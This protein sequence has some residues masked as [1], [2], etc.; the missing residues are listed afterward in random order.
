[1]KQETRDV[2]GMLDAWEDFDCSITEAKVVEVIAQAAAS[3]LEAES[4]NV[5]VE[6][7]DSWNWEA[8]YKSVDPGWY[9]PA[10][11]EE[12]TTAIKQE[13]MEFNP[14][15]SSRSHQHGRQPIAIPAP[16]TSSPMSPLSS[17]SSQFSSLSHSESPAKPLA[18]N[19][20]Y[21]WADAELLGPDSVHQQE[22]EGDWQDG[23]KQF[24]TVRPRA[25]TAPS[26]TPFFT[27]PTSPSMTSPQRDLPECSNPALRPDP[28][29][30]S[31]S[32]SQSLTSLIQ[33]MSTT[34][35]SP[36]WLPAPCISPHETRCEGTGLT[37][38][39]LVHTCQPCTPAI[40]ATQVEGMF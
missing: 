5:K 4:S 9:S 22:P 11:E 16:S 27:K 33:S 7:S 31:S 40:S 26:T 15:V 18:Q 37:D 32:I 28:A 8:G 1:V 14:L 10:A 20:E 19:N 38:V 2:Q 3:V 17:L 30:A 34:S 36:S 23:D 29:P 12:G 21:A 24:A 25:R 39:V 6:G 13:D 35:T